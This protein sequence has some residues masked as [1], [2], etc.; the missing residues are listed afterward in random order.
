MPRY[1]PIMADLEG[2]P[3]LVVGGGTIAERKLSGLLECGAAVTV[4]APEWTDGIEAWRQQGEVELRAKRYAPGDLADA[5]LVF[6]A[7]DSRE[8]NRMVCEQA[9][10]EGRW[11]SNAAEPESGRFVVPASLRRGKLLLAVSTSGA[12]PGLA[13]QIRD[14]LAASYGDEYEAMLEF[15]EAFRQE[16]KHRL[17]DERARRAWARR[18]LTADLPAVVRSG[19]WETFCR[20]RLAELRQDPAYRH[21]PP[22]GSDK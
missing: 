3:C 8:V 5:A 17:P 14:E 13:A 12:S 21:E 11:A 18:L 15:L 19:G 20:A 22:A 7:T 10:A 9:E 16:M 2:V 6:A 4:V 1:Y